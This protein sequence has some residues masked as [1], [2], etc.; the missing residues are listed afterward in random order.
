MAKNK[1]GRMPGGNR[2]EGPRREESGK[3]TMSVAEA[4]H[5]GGQREREL[6]QEGHRSEDKKP[7]R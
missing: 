4:G 2:N 1:G 3:G 7:R 6:I 5:R